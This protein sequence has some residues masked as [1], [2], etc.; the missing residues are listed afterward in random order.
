MLY[1]HKNSRIQSLQKCNQF[2][3]FHFKRRRQLLIIFYVCDT[4]GTF[5]EALLVLYFVLNFDLFVLDVKNSVRVTAFNFQL[6][7]NNQI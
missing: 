5:N 3:Y 1:M 7:I 6:I 4:E 2:T